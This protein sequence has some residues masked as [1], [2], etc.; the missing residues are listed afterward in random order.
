MICY[1]L[2]HQ[3]WIL[4]VLCEHF[5]TFYLVCVPKYF[6]V[7]CDGHM[8]LYVWICKLYDSL[9]YNVIAPYYN[10]VRISTAVIDQSDCNYTFFVKIPRQRSVIAT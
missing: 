3:H 2:K 4:H 8:F 5:N 1:S 7:L 10:T 9:H 6:K